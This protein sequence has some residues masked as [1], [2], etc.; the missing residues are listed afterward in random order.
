RREYRH[1]L[2]SRGGKPCH[3]CGSLIE[4]QQMSGRRIYVCEKCQNR[5]E[6]RRA[7]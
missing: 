5:G 4:K 2:F 7:V 1:Y 6:L 3:I